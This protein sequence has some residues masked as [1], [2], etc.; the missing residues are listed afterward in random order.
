MTLHLDYETRSRINL[1]DQGAYIYAK[2]SSTEI[3]CMYYAFD[4]GP[5][6]GWWPED[7]FPKAVLDAMRKGEDRSLHAHNSQ[8]E[9]LITE[10]VLVR[11]LNNLHLKNIPLHA[12]YCTASQARRR[13]LPGGL[14][15]LG[16]I[17]NLDVQKSLVGKQLINKLCIPKLNGHVDYENGV[18][19]YDPD[20]LRQMG[21]Y[22]SD[23]VEVERAAAKMSPPLTD[24]EF[25]EFVLMEEINDR[26]IKVDVELAIAAASYAA[27]ETVAIGQELSRMTNGQITAPRQFQRLKDY[28]APYMEADDVLRKIMTKHKTTKGVT[29]ISISLDKNV[30]SAILSDT[31]AF[32]GPVVELTKL[33]SEAS[34]ASTSKFAKMA[35]LAGADFRVRGAYIWNGASQTGRH[36]SV[37]LQVHNFLRDC[38]ED[39]EALRELIVGNWELDEPLA[40]LASML[41]P[42]LMAGAG[43]RLVV[44]DWSSIEAVVLPWLSGS[45]GGDALCAEYA[46]TFSDPSAVDMYTRQAKAMG[47]SDRQTGKVAI[48]SCGFQGGYR[49]VQGMARNYGLELDKPAAEAIKTGWRNANPWASDARTGMWAVFERQAMKAMRDPGVGYMAGRCTFM[50]SSEWDVLWDILPSGKVLSYP[51]PRLETVKT[52]WGAEKL[53]ITVVKAAWAPAAGSSDDWPRVA[54]YGGMLAQ[55]ATQ[56]TAAEILGWGLAGMSGLGWPVIGHTHDEMICEVEDGEVADCSAAMRWVMTVGPSWASGLPLA[57]SIFNSERY[58][59]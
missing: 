13:A 57:C 34:N 38:A 9:R 21:E 12:W 36:S 27:E 1:L 44:G 29:K 3:I 33:V 6:L 32:A 26:G 30:R 5:V 18:F 25:D 55:G 23:D 42:A 17:L 22:C 58:K 51:Q 46:E 8:F 28:L 54:L 41:R 37:G 47:S 52:P 24:L 14:D 16:R 53:A 50:Y 4:D 45:A 15:K 10:H 56:G 40:D 35:M 11:M 2:D 7:D 31:D 59:K 19:N 49:A 20:L 43:N 39:P 48:L